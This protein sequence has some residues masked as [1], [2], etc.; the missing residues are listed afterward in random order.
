[1]LGV[2]GLYMDIVSA[3]VVYRQGRIRSTNFPCAEASVLPQCENLT[4]EYQ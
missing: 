2:Y 4:L 3:E 1:M